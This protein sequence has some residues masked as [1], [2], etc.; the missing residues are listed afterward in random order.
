MQTSSLCPDPGVRLTVF[1]VDGKD[2]D[3][4]NGGGDDHGVDNEGGSA[5]GGLLLH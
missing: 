3:N 4:G 5:G 1:E 2:V